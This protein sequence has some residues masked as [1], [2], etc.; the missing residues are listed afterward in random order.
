MNDILLP[1]N[2]LQNIRIGISVSSSPD[3]AQLGLLASHCQIALGEIARCVFVLGG[4]LAYGGHIQDTSDSF[5]VFLMRELERYGGA[6]APSTLQ[7]ASLNM[8]LAWQEHRKCSLT[9]LEQASAK[10]GVNGRLIC[11]SPEGVEVDRRQGRGEQ[12]VPVDDASLGKKSLTAMRRFM[13]THT[14]ARILLG[15]KRHGF[16]GE[17]PGLLEEALLAV[18]AQRPLFLAGGFG[19]VTLDIAQV[20][21]PACMTFSRMNTT[22]M[23]ERERRGLEE[24][25]KALKGGGWSALKNGLSDEENRQLAATHRPGEIAA[26]L[27][28]GL[29]RLNLRGDS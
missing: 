7:Q 17:V 15:G 6:H 8:I 19:G 2:V 11:L 28:L 25:I 24:L 27:T 4:S 3:L 23:D 12:A 14:R 26:L 13:T 20:V 9:A 5:T 22:A 18:D 16:E 1:S 21:D 10:L 29:G